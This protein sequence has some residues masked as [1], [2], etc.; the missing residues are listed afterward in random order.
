MRGHLVLRSDQHRTQ[1]ANM[2]ACLQHLHRLLV[3]IGTA[4]APPPTSAA[5]QAHVA[6]L[7][8]AGHESRLRAKR[9]HALKKASRSLGRRPLD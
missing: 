9:S 2:D 6:G 3:A 4:I 1:P 5:Q 8:R 7:A